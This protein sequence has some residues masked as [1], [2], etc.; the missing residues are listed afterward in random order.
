MSVQ[1]N[2]RFKLNSEII[3]SFSGAEQ[4]AIQND[5][6]EWNCAVNWSYWG[7]DY[8]PDLFIPSEV[9]VI[10]N[11][12]TDGDPDNDLTEEEYDNAVATSLEGLNNITCD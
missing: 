7:Y 9:Q 3:G 5:C 6:I 4:D 12:L 8:L 10:N 1:H 2:A 11:N